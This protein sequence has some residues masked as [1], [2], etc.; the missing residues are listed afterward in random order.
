[1]RFFG[2]EKDESVIIIGCGRLGR[3]LAYAISGQGQDVTVIDRD[4]TALKKLPSSYRG[5]VLAGDGTD[6]DILELAGIRNA[7]SLIAATGDEA[8]NIMIAQIASRRY[9]IKN[10]LAYIDDMSKTISCQ[11]M[12][13]ITVCPTVLS[14]NEAQRVLFNAKEEKAV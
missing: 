10:V 7:G 14:V 8:A 2:R 9:Q 4:E 13:I 1:M 6:T 11:G 3:N 12:N 5:S